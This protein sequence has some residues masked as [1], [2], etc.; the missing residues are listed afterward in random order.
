MDYG[1]P[2]NA[3]SPRAAVRLLQNREQRLTRRNGAAFDARPDRRWRLRSGP[4]PRHLGHLRQLRLL[5]ARG[6][7]LLE[8]GG[9]V[10]NHFPGS[11]SESLIVQSSALAGAGYATTSALPSHSEHDAIR[12]RRRSAGARKRAI[13][14]RPAGSS[15]CNGARVFHQQSRR[16]RRRAARFDPLADTSLAIRINGRHALSLSYQLARRTS[17]LLALPDHIQT[18]TT[19]GIFYTFLGSGG[20]GAVR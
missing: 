12:L 10:R 20:L 5:R 2:G 3:V 1:Y 4:T 15:G 17:D 16:V 18:R 7:S 14:C 13:Y 8:H 19:A 11:I 6:H 9:V